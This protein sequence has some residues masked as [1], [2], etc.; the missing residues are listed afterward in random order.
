VNTRRNNRRRDLGVGSSEQALL[1]RPLTAR[2]VVLSLLLG[3]HPP[4]AP[5]A[6]L[7]RWCALF[8]ISTT[9]T[10][11]ALSRM[12][13]H[14]ELTAA[15]ATYALAGRVL[16]RQ[17]EQD[18]VLADPRRGWDGSWC[19]AIVEPGARSA[20]ARGALRTAAARLR[21]AEL[22]DGVWTRPDNLTAEAWPAD[23]RAVVEAQCRWWR[24]AVPEGA[25][26]TAERLFAARAWAERGRVL[27]D[28][29]V[30]ATDRLDPTGMPVAF[31]TGAAA[32]QHLRRDPLLPQE[33]VPDGWPASDLRDAYVRYVARFGEVIAAWSAGANGSS[34]SG[35]APQAD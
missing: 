2:S 17:A 4:R 16:G 13:E 31:V 27:L 15:D 19:L 14:G 9:A 25:D 30:T 33:L 26:G 8:G 23:A 22:R 3:R 32:A 35:A 12:V 20:D 10:R 1:E 28:R 21:L 34:G 18:V 7:V 24:G 29:L 11:V 6:L 5:V